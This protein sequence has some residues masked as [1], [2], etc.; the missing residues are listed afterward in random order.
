MRKI[1]LALAFVLVST[2]SIRAQDTTSGVNTLTAF[3]MG[4]YV[5]NISSF[6]VP[7]EG[8]NKNGLDMGVRIMCRPMHLLSGG[9]EVGYSNV[10]SV[11]QTV[12][13]DQDTSELHSTMSVMPIMLVFSMSPF[14]N[15]NVNLGTGLY[16]IVSSE[17]TSFGHTASTTTTSGVFMASV[18]Y[19]KPLSDRFGL[20]GEVKYLHVSKYTDSNLSFL[21]SLSYR[22]LEW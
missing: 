19:I 15:I 21:L 14:E 3:V 17:V 7:I 22:F 13:Y 12:S 16:A 11:D 1:L 8:I 18:N 6:P 2:L 20:G 9:I 5:R 10:F 4:G